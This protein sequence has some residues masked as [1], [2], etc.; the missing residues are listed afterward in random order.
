MTFEDFKLNRQLLNAIEEAGYE[1]PS[2]IQEKAIPLLLAGHDVIGVAQTGTGKTAAFMLPLLMKLKYA[3]GE[4]PR[5]LILAPTREL[6]MQ[7]YEHFEML[8]KY[9][10]LRAVAL[11]GGSGSIKR[12][13]EQVREG[14]DLIIATPGRLLDIYERNELNLRQIKT[15]IM[16]EADR[17]LD[18][19]FQPQIN[20]LLEIISSKKRQNALFSATMPEK[21][22]KLT[23][24]FLEFPKEINISPVAVTA[25]TVAQKYYEVPNFRTKINLLD[26]LLKDKEVFNK[27]IVFTRTKEV[28]NNVYK[29][30]GRKVDESVKV[31]HSNKDQNARSNAFSDFKNGDIRILVATDV[32]ARGLDVSEVSH[33]INFEVPKQYDDYVHRIGRT[34]RAEKEGIAITFANVLDVHHIKRIEKLIGKQIPNE[35]IP[36][37]VE[38]TQTPFEENQKLLRA[39]DFIRQKEDPNYKGAFHHKKRYLDPKNNNK[40]KSKS[41]SNRKP[42]KG[43]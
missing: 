4:N 22:V 15:M 32:A 20:R 2:P 28:A 11:Y 33:V 24:D 8:G 17:I 19:G 27:V 3:Q 13:L 7:I 21:V 26:F 25:E 9:T 36:T 29:F 18:M 39:L 31:I 38:I 30:L 10:D 35:R 23:E 6:V 41:S 43:R 14:M 37:E 42:K 40:K 16:D 34:G 5:A 12:Q 1:K